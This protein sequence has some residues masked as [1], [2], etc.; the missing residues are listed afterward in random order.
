MRSLS[1]SSS[2]LTNGDDDI[3]FNEFRE[4]SKSIQWRVERLNP[5]RYSPKQTV[6]MNVTDKTAVHLA[7][8]R[9]LSRVKVIT[10]GATTTQPGAHPAD[11]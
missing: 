9:E 5:A 2:S 11:S 8:I 6:D 7:A 3:G 4:L 10:N 1:A